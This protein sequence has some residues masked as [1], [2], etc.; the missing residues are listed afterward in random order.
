MYAQLEIDLKCGI[1]KQLIAN[2]LATHYGTSATPPGPILSALLLT[3]YAQQVVGSFALPGVNVLYIYAAR[4][5][6]LVYVV[7]ADLPVV[8][9]QC[10]KAVERLR[11]ISKVKTK[12][13]GASVLIQ[14]AGH[15]DLDI[16]TGAEVGWVKPFLDALLDRWFSKVVAALANAGGASWYFTAAAGAT[17]ASTSL[18]AAAASAAVVNVIP[19]PVA[20]AVIALL[21][22]VVAVLFEAIQSAW[23][24]DAWSWKESK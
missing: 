7:G 16:L 6:L 20:S 19:S 18:P 3:A 9:K 11:S 21:A 8:K 24:T 1:D 4:D 2:P 10:V 12:K 13:L 14:V 5:E 23:R 15:A 22:T 17:A